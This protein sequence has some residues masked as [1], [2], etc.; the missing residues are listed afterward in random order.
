M[1][2][3]VW[4]AP[5]LAPLYTPTH[6]YAAGASVKDAHDLAGLA[7]HMEAQVKF[8]QVL[9]H[10]IADAPEG[11]LHSRSRGRSSAAHAAQQQTCL[12]ASRVPLGRHMVVSACRQLTS[13]KHWTQLH[14]ASNS[15]DKPPGSDWL[16]QPAGC[17]STGL[18]TCVIGIHKM[19]LRLASSPSLPLPPR[20]KKA[21]R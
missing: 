18:P 17:W 12:E 4:C 14:T 13:S 20:R 15:S 21:P 16:L 19:S 7:V 5:V 11:R 6:L 3:Q 8:Q 2:V 9:K 10:I 1:R